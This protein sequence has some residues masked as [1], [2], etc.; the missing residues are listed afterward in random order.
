MLCPKCDFDLNRIGKIDVIA[1]GEKDR[2]TKSY[3]CPNC[4]YTIYESV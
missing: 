4:G 2:T 1:E 3:R